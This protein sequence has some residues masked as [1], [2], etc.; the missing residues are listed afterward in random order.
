MLGLSPACLPA[1]GNSTFPVECSLPLGGEVY[2]YGS[3]V[4]LYKIIPLLLEAP[5]MFN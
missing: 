1:G 4:D 2:Q 3:S 5:L